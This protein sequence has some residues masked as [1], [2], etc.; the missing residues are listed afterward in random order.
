MAPALDTIEN[1][2]LMPAIEPVEGSIFH[3]GD[4]VVRHGSTI[5]NPATPEPIEALNMT[6]IIRGVEKREAG[7]Y[8]YTIDFPSL[9]WGTS[10]EGMLLCVLECDLII[11]A[12]NQ[13]D[14]AH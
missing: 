5:L 2:N 14:P 10:Y 7:D 4:I 9:Y 1:N 13:V 11:Y 6:G 3:L 8:L 12:G